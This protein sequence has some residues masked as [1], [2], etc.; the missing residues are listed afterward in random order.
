MEREANDSRFELKPA[1]HAAGAGTCDRAIV[2]CAGQGTRLR[3]LTDERPKPM[4]PVAGRPILDYI[5]EWLRDQGVEQVG[6]NLHYMPDAITSH[7]GSTRYGLSFRYSAERVLLGSAGALR[8]LRNFL[9]AGSDP[10]FAAVY[11]DTLSTLPL[12]PLATW[13]RESGAALTMAVMDH[14]K[15]TEAGIVELVGTRPWSGGLAGQVTRIKEKP[16]PEEVFSTVANAGVF[17]MDAE[18]IEHVPESGASD[19]ARDLIPNLLAA[20]KRVSAWKF[21][22]SATVW[23]VGTWESYERANGEWPRIWAE[24]SRKVD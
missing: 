9:A 11:G 16:A 2:F 13:H 12:G 8:P 23:D 7:L 21:P 24:R 5:L 19:L 20:G 17:V 6:I 3:P 22:S 14:P 18:V 1:R 15:P 4:V 10:T